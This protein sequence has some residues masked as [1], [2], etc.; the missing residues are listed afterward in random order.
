MIIPYLESIEIYYISLNKQLQSIT[1]QLKSMNGLSKSI[2]I[3]WWSNKFFGQSTT[4]HCPSAH[5]TICSYAHRPI[6]TSAQMPIKSNWKSIKFIWTSIGL[7]FKFPQIHCDSF[8]QLSNSFEDQHTPIGHQL[9]FIASITNPL[10]PWKIKWHLQ[11]NLGIHWNKLRNYC[12]HLKLYYFLL[13]SI[14][15]QFNLKENQ[16]KAIGNL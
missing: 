14:E 1:H 6:C 12:I 13:E 9:K 11:H 16:S 5:E 4:I 7:D 2:Q 10:N 3:N 8:K 15:H